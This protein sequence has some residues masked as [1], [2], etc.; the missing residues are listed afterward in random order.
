MRNEVRQVPLPE[1]LCAAAEQKF[2]GRFGKVEEL[3]I[4]VL[5][6]LLND[7]AARL[8]EAEQKIVEERLRELGY[9]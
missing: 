7:P 4:F 3:L 1:D 8:D 2:G 9:I 6:D 5:Q